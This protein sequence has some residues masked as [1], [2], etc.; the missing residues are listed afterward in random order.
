MYGYGT[1][2]ARGLYRQQRL[3]LR[4]KVEPVAGL[5]LSG[6]RPVFEHPSEMSAHGRPEILLGAGPRRGHRRTDTAP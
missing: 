3:Y 6:H 2:P 4:L 5:G 1:A